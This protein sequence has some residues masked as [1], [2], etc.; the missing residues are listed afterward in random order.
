MSVYIELCVL[1]VSKTNINN[2]K[3]DEGAFT[4]PPCDMFKFNVNKI[5]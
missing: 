4:L 2:Y 5:T 3:I 1:C